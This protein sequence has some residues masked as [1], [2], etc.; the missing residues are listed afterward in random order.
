MHRRRQL[1]LCLRWSF[2]LAIGVLVVAA[3]AAASAAVAG[4]YRGQTSQH[5]TV[6]FSIQSG[7]VKNFKL[8]VLDKCPDGHTLAVVE[9]YPVPMAIR[10]R[11]FGGKFVPEG[12]VRG[13]VTTLT[14]KVDR[15]KVTG[16]LRDTSFSDREGALCH[17]SAAFTA[18]HLWRPPGAQQPVGHSLRIARLGTTIQSANEWPNR[19]KNTRK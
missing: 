16:G 1:R 8:T 14:A 7:K 15:G 10:N 12:G 13:E 4:R 2:G 18:K 11:K 6:S 3:S 17:G 5:Q 9:E 19:P